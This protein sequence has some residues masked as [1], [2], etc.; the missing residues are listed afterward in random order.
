MEMAICRTET[1]EL[2]YL[3]PKS[4]K[5]NRRPFP[6]RQNFPVHFQID[7]GLNMHPLHVMPDSRAVRI[8]PDA[9]IVKPA[10]E[11]LSLDLCAEG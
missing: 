10:A 5:R 3:E 2:E 9:C 11:Q 1:I 6:D 4:I 8:E 7:M